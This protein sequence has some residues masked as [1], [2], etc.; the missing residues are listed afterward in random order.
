MSGKKETRDLSRGERTCGPRLEVVGYGGAAVLPD[1]TGQEVRPAEA[2]SH[3][4][5]VDGG[6]DAGGGCRRGRRLHVGS[7]SWNFRPP[8][9]CDHRRENGK[10]I[11]ERQAMDLLFLAQSAHHFFF[12]LNTL[13][14]LKLMAPC[15]LGP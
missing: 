11:K 15:H 10:E 1:A 8:P 3:W 2:R 13:T 4:G 5:E 12:K 14:A 9:P 7:G 6:R